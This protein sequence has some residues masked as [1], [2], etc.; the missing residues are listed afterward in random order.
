MESGSL[1]GV[2]ASMSF[3][4]T[5]G[6]DMNANAALL[7]DHSDGYRDHAVRSAVTARGMVQ[8]TPNSRASASQSWRKF[9][10]P[11]PLLE[12]LLVD[13]TESD[14]RFRN[15]GGED[16]EWSAA[17]AN[18][19][20]LGA[21]G[22][23]NTTLRLGGRHGTLVRTLPLSPDFG[24]TRERELRTGELGTT[25]QADLD[26][27]ILPV[28][29]H[30]TVGASLDIGSIDSRYFSGITDGQHTLDTQGDGR[31]TSIGL[32]AH[33]VDSPTDWLRW[34]IGVRADRLHDTFSAGS[35]DNDAEH[36]AF[37]PKGGVNVRYSPT[38]HVWLSASRTFKAPTL[39][40]LFDQRPIPVPF[41]PF[42]L[43][44]SNPD[45]N[46]QRGTSLETGIYHDAVVASARL[47]LTVTLYEIAMKDELDFD[48]Q[49]L[50][51]VN[52]GRSRHRG[53]EAG[54]SLAGANASVYAT[55]ALQDAIARV[56]NNA[57]KQLK[58]IPGQVWSTGVTF[59]P[60][61]LGTATVSATHMADMFIDD[62]NTRR[63]PSWT[64]VDVQVSRRI[65]YAAIVVGARNLLDKRFSSTGFLDPSG[66]GE[67]YFYPAAG[68]VFTLG[69]RNGR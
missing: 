15:D 17:I 23:L 50:K 13:G 40:Q 53:A 32:F 3:P 27:N 66:S 41:P 45:L 24:D 62:A 65:G 51:Y 6:D 21:G 56:G 31:R 11:G 12:R 8:V 2:T 28:I 42:S 9:D 25:V 61:R 60:P 35:G 18:R 43:T 57:G 37:S 54:L 30:A 52:I 58:A 68:R 33:F 46:P 59:S 63:I 19:G 5:L 4:A 39:D 49:A 22:T 10:E 1:A 34:T 26:A 20:S 69:V 67:A 29:E 55:M 44:T 64:R 38:G 36:F 48:V 14:P 47:S 7:F 16:R